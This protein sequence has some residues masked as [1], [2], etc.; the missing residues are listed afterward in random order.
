[1]SRLRTGVAIQLKE[2]GEQQPVG[3]AV[4]RSNRTES[5]QLM[6]IEKTPVNCCPWFLCVWRG[7]GQ[8]HKRGCWPQ[9]TRSTAQSLGTLYLP[10]WK[11]LLNFGLFHAANTGLN[12]K[13]LSS[14]QILDKLTVL[15]FH[16]ITETARSCTH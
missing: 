12:G 11:M 9:H 8:Q 1:M 14:P 10:T 7:N 2:V 13:N 15:Y 6:S 3:H 5:C 4:F 16:I